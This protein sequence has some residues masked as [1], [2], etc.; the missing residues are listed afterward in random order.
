MANLAFYA[1]QRIT[2]SLLASI[3]PIAAWKVADQSVTS[4][5]TTLIPD[6]A[7]QTAVVTGGI[8]WVECQVKYE[9]RKSTR[10]NSSHQIISYAVFC[11][12][13]KKITTP[14]EPSSTHPEFGCHAI[15]NAIS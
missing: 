6:T 13:K 9:D 7:L 12:K 14:H 8:Y 11:L 10:L 15:G 5:A 3:A 4:N 2:A 1:G